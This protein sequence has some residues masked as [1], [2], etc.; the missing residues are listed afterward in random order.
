M[1]ES[2]CFK[3]FRVYFD[4]LSEGGALLSLSRGAYTFSAIP[5]LR[6]GLTFLASLS[7][8]V[9]SVYMLINE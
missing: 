3:L 9:S 8:T 4:N 1:F 7:F 2:T 6:P 5:S